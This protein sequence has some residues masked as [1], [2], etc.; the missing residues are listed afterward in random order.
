M[1]TGV[2]AEVDQFRDFLDK[3][4][5]GG[6]SFGSLVEVVD[7][8]RRYQEEL[9][10][11]KAKLEVAEQQVRQGQ[12]AAFDSQAIMQQVNKRLAKQCGAE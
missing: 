5:E 9:A 2:S 3:Q 10:D 11:L 1:S 6:T 7:E 4:Q 8:F 12:V